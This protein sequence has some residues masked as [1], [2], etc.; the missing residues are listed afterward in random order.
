MDAQDWGR[1]VESDSSLHMAGLK[2][3]EIRKLVLCCLGWYVDMMSMWMWDRLIKM[4]YQCSG[5]WRVVSLSVI[6]TLGSGIDNQSERVH[7]PT[8]HR[9]AGVQ[10]VADVEKYSNQRWFI[11]AHNRIG[12]CICTIRGT[13][14]ALLCWL[15]ITC[16]LLDFYKKSVDN[17]RLFCDA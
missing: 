3:C 15:Y 4:R 7:S 12:Y 8:L 17:R 10:G 5:Y 13:L 16:H 1:Q 9:I 2:P 14:Y 6:V 11:W